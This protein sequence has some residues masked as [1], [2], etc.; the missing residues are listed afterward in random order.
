MVY[1]ENLAILA[2]LEW[3]DS[4]ESPALPDSPD[5]PYQPDLPNKIIT[6]HTSITSII[7]IPISIKFTQVTGMYRFIRLTT[8]IRSTRFARSTKFI[9]II[10]GIP[11]M[12]QVLNNGNSCSVC[13]FVIAALGGLKEY[14]D[15]NNVTMAHE[16]RMVHR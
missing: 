12:Q 2:I 10:I 13:E 8:S 16:V 15:F 6:K 1:L 11:G 3:P 9:Q 14:Y 4:P 7:R 5:P